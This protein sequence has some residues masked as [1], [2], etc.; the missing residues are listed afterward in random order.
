MRNRHLVGSYSRTMPRLLWRS[1][2]GLRFLMSEV[3]RG[4]VT[5]STGRDRESRRRGICLCSCLDPEF[6][7]GPHTQM[8]IPFDPV[9]GNR[10]GVPHHRGT[11]LIRN[12]PPLQEVVTSSTGRDR[13]SRRGW[14]RCFCSCLDPV[15]HTGPNPRINVPSTFTGVPRS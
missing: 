8:N 14:I 1:L 13:E 2:G 5:S 10:V 9:R 15:L 12:S 3:L 7:I 4:V 6:N 11:S